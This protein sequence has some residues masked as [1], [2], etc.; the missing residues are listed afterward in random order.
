MNL[1]QRKNFLIHFVVCFL[2]STTIKAQLLSD[3][4][5]IQIFPSTNQQAEIHISVNKNNPLN[6]VAS[7][8]SAIGHQG[9]YISNDGGAHLG[10]V[11]PTAHP[12]PLLGEGAIS[13]VGGHGPGGARWQPAARHL[14]PAPDLQGCCAE[15]TGRH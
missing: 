15:E 7:A 10:P 1:K 3:G 11:L 5:D 12:G 14:L 2:S 6:I 4:K 13:P 9:R 8:I